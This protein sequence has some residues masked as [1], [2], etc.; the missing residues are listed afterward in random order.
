MIVEGQVSPFGKYAI[1]SVRWTFLR[2]TSYAIAAG[3]TTAI[4]FAGAAFYSFVW[5]GQPPI[6][7][8][9][10][11]KPPPDA[12]PRAETRPGRH[13]VVGISTS[14]GLDQGIYAVPI[15]ADANR[16]ARAQAHS[17][18][19]VNARFQQLSGGFFRIR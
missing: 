18:T 4:F 6:S 19:L 1:L 17:L 11:P 3:M 8:A 10:S 12:N 2:L 7:A 15:R 5:P 16:P 13:P 14:S 9:P